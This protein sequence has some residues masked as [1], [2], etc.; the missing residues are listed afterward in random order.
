[1]SNSDQ[2]DDH[3]CPPPRT[4]VNIKGDPGD[5]GEKGDRGYT[6]SIGP[7]GEKG[8]KGERGPIGPQGIQGI[9]GEQGIQGIQ[10]LPGEDGADGADGEQGIQG[11]QGEQ[12]TSGFVNCTEE[13]AAGCFDIEFIDQQGSIITKTFQGCITVFSCGFTGDPIC[14]TPTSI[15]P[16]AADGFVKFN[17]PTPYENLVNGFYI[18]PVAGSV[19]GTV[20]STIEPIT[21]VTDA[22]NTLTTDAAC[23]SIASTDSFMFRDWIEKGTGLPGAIKAGENLECYPPLGS[24]FQ[25]SGLNPNSSRL[26]MGIAGGDFGLNNM[27]LEAGNIFSSDN[28]NE[29]TLTDHYAEAMYFGNNDASVYNG[30]SFDGTFMLADSSDIL[31]YYVTCFYEPVIAELSLGDN[32]VVVGLCDS[33]GE[34]DPATPVTLV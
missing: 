31:L 27:T 28:S 8:A 2:Y 22:G 29:P 6:G 30:G 9:K 1:M 3:H 16:I 23:I 34:I 25:T 13:N 14:I 24:W 17:Y 18:E 12:G 21:F 15:D 33:S 5:P 7:T 32:P 10:G 26:D 11:I 19:L 20:T 4:V